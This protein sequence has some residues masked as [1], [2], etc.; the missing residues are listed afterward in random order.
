[1]NAKVDC[2]LKVL[3]ILGCKASL[4]QRVA[5]L[6]ALQELQKGKTMSDEK[7]EQEQILNRPPE[8]EL[9]ASTKLWQ[10]R[11][12]R[13]TQLDGHCPCR[14]V[15]Y[16]TWVLRRGEIHLKW[17]AEPEYVFEASV[18]RDHMGGWKWEPLDFTGLPAEFFA[19]A[20][21]AFERA[22]KTDDAPSVVPSKPLAE[23]TAGL[24]ST[25]VERL[26]ATARHEA[27]T[28]ERGRAMKIATTT[29]FDVCPPSKLPAF[30]A[31]RIERGASDPE[32]SPMTIAK[33]INNLTEAFAQGAPMWAMDLEND[34][35]ALVEAER[36]RTAPSPESPA[37]KLM[38]P[39]RISRFM[40]KWAICSPRSNAWHAMMADLHALVEA[41]ARRDARIAGN[42]GYIGED[43]PKWIDGEIRKRAGLQ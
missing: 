19:E 8:H 36:K 9:P 25:K 35:E 42:A 20:L 27:A 15:R 33:V 6:E 5:I 16:Y 22:R 17:H 38:I 1:M 24:T 26:L 34:L 28:V 12:P 10:G 4:E 18:T 11:M 29:Q 3:G 21:E 40:E 23:E 30:I 41:Q 2:L 37:E 13:P 7:A 43:T 14:V 39:D 31:E 32:P